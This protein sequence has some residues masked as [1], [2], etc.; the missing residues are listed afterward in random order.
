MLTITAT[1]KTRLWREQNRERYLAREKAHYIAKRDK[2]VKQKKLWKK[3]NRDR[4]RE[5]GR[6]HYARHK[7]EYL[8]YGR[9]YKKS[10]QGRINHNATQARRRERLMGGS[11]DQE[12]AEYFEI[13]YGD[14]CA[15]CGSTEKITIDHVVPVINGGDGSWENLTAA[16]SKCNSKKHAKPLL[17][18]LLFH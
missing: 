3:A 7:D 12:L 10:E 17:E 18:W 4:V 16:C 9:T 5:L 11:T 15:Y 2:M 8:E 13:L 14:P 6:Q 1:E